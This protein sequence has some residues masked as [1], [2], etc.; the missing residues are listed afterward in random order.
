MGLDWNPGNKPKP[1]FEREFVDLFYALQGDPSPE[2]T[3]QEARFRE[4][5][6]S[7]FETLGAP[8][9]GFDSRADAWALEALQ[10]ARQPKP[11]SEW[12]ASLKG[13]YV[14]DLVPP[15]HGLPRYSN[16]SPGGYVER[17]SFRAQFLADS[18]E[19]IGPELLEQAYESKLPPVF[20]R[21][22]LALLEK[23]RLFVATR[24]LDPAK[25][26][27][28]EDPESDEFRADVTRE[29]GRWCLF[30][31]RKGHILDAYW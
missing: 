22:G 18:E 14:L 21:Y 1:G 29:A 9:V 17:F 11:E 5:S 28:S 24:K 27:S 10:R 23:F 4:I 30:W 19:I 8:R 15:C 31:S 13:F 26:E 7:A 6:I 20:E 3:R 25:L 12:L 16:G 2:R